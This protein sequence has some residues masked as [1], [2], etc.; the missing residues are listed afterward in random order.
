MTENTPLEESLAQ[1]LDDEQLANPNQP[2]ILA[3]KAII[4]WMAEEFDRQLERALSPIKNPEHKLDPC[5][6]LGTGG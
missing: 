3:A 6:V 2:P 4:Q 5:N 1:F